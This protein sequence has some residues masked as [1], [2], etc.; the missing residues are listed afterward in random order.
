MYVARQFISIV[1]I[2]TFPFPFFHIYQEMQEGMT[3]TV[4]MHPDE[5]HIVKWG[6]GSLKITYYDGDRKIEEQVRHLDVENKF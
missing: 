6:K 2:R 5:L 1:Q 3:C 4:Q